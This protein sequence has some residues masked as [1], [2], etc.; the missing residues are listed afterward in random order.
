MGDAMKI[1]AKYAEFVGYVTFK[2][3]RF[4]E[5][6]CPDKAKEMMTYQ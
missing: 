3:G 5:W 2:G 4:N 6:R 1:R